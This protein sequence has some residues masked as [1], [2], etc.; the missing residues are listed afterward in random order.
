MT[1]TRMQIWKGAVMIIVSPLAAEVTV[2]MCVCAVVMILLI[3]M[4]KNVNILNVL[5]YLHEQILYTLL[6]VECT[7][8]TYYPMEMK[9]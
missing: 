2:W 7:E 8:C 1:C 4:L 6:Q 5:Y 9:N 3:I